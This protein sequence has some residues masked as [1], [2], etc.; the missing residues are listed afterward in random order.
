MTDSNTDNNND[1][2]EGQRSLFIYYPR[3]TSTLTSEIQKVLEVLI[4]TYGAREIAASKQV[5]EKQKF[6]QL[7]HK[8]AKNKILVRRD[9]EFEK[10]TTSNLPLPRV[11]L[12][13]P[14][15]RTP[16]PFQIEHMERPMH[17]IVV[18]DD[19]RT[20]YEHK[21]LVDSGDDIGRIV[22]N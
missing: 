20:A 18:P 22:Q 13:M 10:D 3:G 6:L 16:V 12:L 2:P 14:W 19:I 4:A 11:T 21:S 15:D 5:W 7:L 8:S 17:V 9:L 1:F